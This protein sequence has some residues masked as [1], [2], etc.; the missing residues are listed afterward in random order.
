MAGTV[1]PP[2]TTALRALFPERSEEQTRAEI[3]RTSYGGLLLRS[4]VPLRTGAL[5]EIE[6][7][8][9]T[10]PLGAPMRLLGEVKWSVHEPDDGHWTVGVFFLLATAER[11]FT[12]FL[13]RNRDRL[14][15]LAK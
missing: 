3:V 4:A 10:A 13:D 9:T 14:E 1:Q 11:M 8:D 5:V 15:K 7:E 6:I 12:L 2:R